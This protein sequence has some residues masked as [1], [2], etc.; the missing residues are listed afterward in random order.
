MHIPIG[1]PVA[2]QEQERRPPNAMPLLNTVDWFY[3]LAALPR[4]TRRRGGCAP[5][6]AAVW[7]SGPRAV[8]EHD[9]AG[10]WIIAA[11]PLA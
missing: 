7:Q 3:R 4:V 6:V 8:S 2:F 5:G 11:Y 9:S 1:T 10:S